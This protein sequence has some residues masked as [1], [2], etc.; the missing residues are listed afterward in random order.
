MSALGKLVQA[1]GIH[2][3]SISYIIGSFYLLLFHIVSRFFAFVSIFLEFHVDPICD[4]SVNC[5]EL[6][7]ISVY[8]ARY[9]ISVFYLV[10]SSQVRTGG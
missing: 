4:H 9:I 6:Y 8:L 5:G 3:N 1:Y 2:L 10:N 7:L